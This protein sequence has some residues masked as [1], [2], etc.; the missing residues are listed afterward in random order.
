MH[1]LSFRVLPL[2]LAGAL[3]APSHPAADTPPQKAADEVR[4]L[5][6]LRSSLT[7]P[8][9]IAELVGIASAGG[10]N[11]LL[12]QVRGRGDAYY[13][14]QVDPRASALN[15]Q[16]A[17]FDPLNTTLE[18]AHA[19][20]LKVHAWINVNLVS[21]AAVPADSD[22]HI[23]SRRPEW[24]MV[25]R[26]LATEL[27]RLDSRNAGYLTRLSRWTL[28]QKDSIE[29]L[30][31]SPIPEAAQDYTVSVVT[32]LMQSYP[33]DGAHLD[34][35]RYPS[36]EFDYSKTALQAF[37]QSRVDA[38][39]PQERDRLDQ[40][41]RAD[42][43]IW[44]RSFPE[45]WESF[46]RDRL[47]AL[48]EKIRRAVKAARPDAILSSAVVPSPT[49]ARD[50][51]LQDWQTWAATGTL[52]VLC[53][54]AYSTTPQGFSAQLAATTGAS[55]GRPV[56][57]GI[58]A[59]RLPVGQTAAHMTAA[60]QAGVAG[61]LLFSYDSLLTSRAPTGTYFTRLRPA[62]VGTSR[63]NRR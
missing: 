47:T 6:V 28:S 33:L 20:G 62:L 58:G 23:A 11:T 27:S 18:T 56:W 17:S 39:R 21:S 53:P 19:A 5:W 3:L 29:G 1:L 8:E 54:M 31:L 13:M 35:I 32:D 9:T 37:R 4:G 14:S 10:Y 12:V 24:L 15:E 59:W 50:Q 41:S 46:R 52:D 42:P 61:I 40:L 63:E 60:R 2:V 44:T 25:P 48:V 43:T 22:E 7:S 55:S 49:Q 51:Y 38:V 36:Q 30:Y 26:A 34:Y 45:T 57:M 16:P